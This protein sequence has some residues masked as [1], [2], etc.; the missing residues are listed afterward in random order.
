M[1]SPQK[2]Q[3]KWG[4]G[5]CLSSVPPAYM[6]QFQV[7]RRMQFGQD[8]NGLTRE[9]KREMIIGRMRQFVPEGAAAAAALSPPSSSSAAASAVV[10]EPLRV[11][12][13]EFRDNNGDGAPMEVPLCRRCFEFAYMIPPTTFDDCM[14]TIQKERAARSPTAAAAAARES[15]P[16]LASLRPLGSHAGS[17]NSSKMSTTPSIASVSSASIP[18]SSAAGPKFRYGSY[19]EDRGPMSQG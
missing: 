4:C 8:P 16:L 3:Q 11:F 1:S 10:T 7:A 17:S 9:S 18:G 12:V 5:V 6:A 15:T 14:H 19:N 13:E 2:G